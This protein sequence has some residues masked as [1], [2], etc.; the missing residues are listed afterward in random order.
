M[1]IPSDLLTTA[2]AA[3][4]LG[5]SP[6]S[7]RHNIRRGT[8]VSVRI[9]ART[10]A[11]PLAEVDRYKRESL[12]KRGLAGVRRNKDEDTATRTPVRPTSATPKRQ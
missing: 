7:V 12:G 3:A 10:H 5:L 6:S 11:V 8:L 1:P 2:E 4:E 9:D